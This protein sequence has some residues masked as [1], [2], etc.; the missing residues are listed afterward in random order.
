M[1]LQKAIRFFLHPVRVVAV[2]MLFL[3]LFV[4]ACAVSPGL[5]RAIHK[6]ADQADHHCAITVLAGGQIDSPSG[7]IPNVVPPSSHYVTVLP[8]ESPALNSA[9]DLLPPGR[10]PPVGPSK[11]V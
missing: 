9:I 10:A 3:F 4:L 2:V 8:V 1:H 5:H 6:D 11:A 7:A